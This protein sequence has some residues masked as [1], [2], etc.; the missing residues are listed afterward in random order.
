MFK[1][2][3]QEKEAKTVDL[4]HCFFWERHKSLWELKGRLGR[5]AASWGWGETGANRSPYDHWARICLRLDPRWILG[6]C[7][8]LPPRVSR[9]WKL[10][11]ALGFFMVILWI[12]IDRWSSAH[13][14]QIP[15]PAGRRKTPPWDTRYRH[16]RHLT[17]SLQENKRLYNIVI[18]H[19][20]QCLECVRKKNL[21]DVGKWTLKPS[22]ADVN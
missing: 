13:S 17:E 1:R 11:A 8:L 4:F 6:G 20:L 3:A 15:V 5:P 16:R 9:C 14:V 10:W 22:Q 2:H 7:G 12:R 21:Q 18:I 19:T